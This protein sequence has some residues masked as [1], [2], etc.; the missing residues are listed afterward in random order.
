[1]IINRVGIEGAL[2]RLATNRPTSPEIDDVPFVPIASPSLS[3][4]SSPASK[5]TFVRRNRDRKTDRHAAAQLP[6][7]K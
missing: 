7:M 3:S 5:E 2:I 4:S 1:M 6:V